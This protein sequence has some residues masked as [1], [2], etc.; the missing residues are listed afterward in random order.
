MSKTM[1]Y[2]PS[3]NCDNVAIGSGI[4]TIHC[5]CSQPF[6]FKC[7]EEAH[8]PCSCTQLSDWKDKCH[9]ES[10]TANCKTYNI[11]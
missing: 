4:T 3:P 8:D 5:S 11:I 7:G 2:C 1:K 10:E 6:C 9:N